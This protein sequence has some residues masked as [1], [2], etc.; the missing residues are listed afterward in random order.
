MAQS[1]EDKK[2]FI[3]D[4]LPTNTRIEVVKIAKDGTSEKKEMDFGDY[5]AMKKQAGFT[6]RAYALGF[7][8]FANKK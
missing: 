4:L 7:S 8:Q 6:Y 5:K 2:R 1:K 3:P